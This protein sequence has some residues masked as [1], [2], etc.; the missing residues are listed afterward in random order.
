MR[1][2][3]EYVAWR[4]GE[5]STFNCWVEKEQPAEET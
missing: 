5:Y 2:F 4:K 3:R 1:S